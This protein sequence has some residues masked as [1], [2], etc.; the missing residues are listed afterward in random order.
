PLA[1]GS[2]PYATSSCALRPVKIP[3][4]L[5]APELHELWLK[6]TPVASQ[7]G[8]VSAAHPA[9]FN[10]TQAPLGVLGARSYSFPPFGTTVVRDTL[11]TSMTP[12]LARSYGVG[13]GVSVS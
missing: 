6:A 10:V 11:S 9:W 1:P 12:T 7:S 8:S 13:M 3:P 4:G 2:V 5:R